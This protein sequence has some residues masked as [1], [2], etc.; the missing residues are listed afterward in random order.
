MKANSFRHQSTLYA[1]VLQM[2]DIQGALG[3]AFFVVC[4]VGSA[5]TASRAVVR[6]VSF[7]PNLRFSRSGLSFCV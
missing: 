4:L 5:V 7:V 1:Q 2:K 3:L 6:R